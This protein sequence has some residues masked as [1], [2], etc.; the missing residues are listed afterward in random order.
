MFLRVGLFTLIISL[1]S[2]GAMA[3]TQWRIGA[4]MA[5]IHINPQKKFN[6]I[7]PGLFVSATFRAGQR[8][9]YGI[10]AGAYVNSY[11]ERTIYTTTYANWHVAQIGNADVRLGGFVGLYEYPVLS[12]RARAIGWPTVGNYILALGPSMKMRFRNGVDF[13]VAFLPVKTKETTG[14][15]TFQLS[16]PFG[17]HR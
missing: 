7:N 6:Q 14:V 12:A 4:N 16:M 15:F 11:S 10:Q 17:R 8:F 3:E 9:E 5:S 1:F 2:H 13:T